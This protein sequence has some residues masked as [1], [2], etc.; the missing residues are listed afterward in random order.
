MQ[1]VF[2]HTE[3]KADNITMFWL[4][5]RQE[6]KYTAG[7]FTELYLPHDKP[8]DR[9]IKRWYTLSS[10]PTEG[11]LAIAT[12]FAKDRGSSF[13][14]TLRALQPGAEVRMADPMGDFVLPK[15]PNIPLV[16]VAGG[17]GITPYRSMV[18][19]LLDM[20]ERR[21]IHLLYSLSTVDEIVFKEIF[22]AYGLKMDII[23]NNPPAGWQGL[24]GKLTAQRILDVAG[25]LQGKQL[26]LSGPEPMVEAFDKDL[27]NLGLL[28]DQIV[29][30]F[31]PG[32]VEI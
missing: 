22:E 29:T 11:L 17:I 24:S 5:P 21:D 25:N 12:K 23:V 2:D 3:P 9:G 8:D 20:N 10:S 26:Y 15:D 16:L 19:W 18:K 31:F 27:K 28:P 1:A 4:K 30:D 13:K 32:Y 7:Q 14:R 6:V